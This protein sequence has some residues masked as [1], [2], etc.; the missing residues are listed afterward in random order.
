MTT[1]HDWVPEDACTLPHRDRPLRLEAFEYL[2]AT[3]LLSTAWIGAGRL[4]LRFYPTRAV[5]Q[6]LRQLTAKEASCCSFFTFDIQPTTAALLVDIR[7]PRNRVDVLIGL[8][9]QALSAMVSSNAGP[10]DEDE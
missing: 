5:E 8:E 7:V 6:Q 9:E 2:F 4:R 1:D 10:A 3:A